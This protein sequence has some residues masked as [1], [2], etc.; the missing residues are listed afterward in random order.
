MMAEPTCME[1]PK[2]NM[3]ANQNSPIALLLLNCPVL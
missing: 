1:K 3:A 2:V